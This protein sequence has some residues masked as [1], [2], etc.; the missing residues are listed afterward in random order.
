[1]S[2][3]RLIR[4]QQVKN[5]L[6][7]KISPVGNRIQRWLTDLPESTARHIADTKRN[8]ELEQLLAAATGIPSVEPF[9]I[10][11]TVEDATMTNTEPLDTFMS[12]GA[13]HDPIFISDNESHVA[14]PLSRE[15]LSPED[16]P[17]DPEVE[18]PLGPAEAINI[19][20]APLRSL[21]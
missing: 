7:V 2:G 18:K 21:F 17:K 13:G 14:S 15:P 1:M 19:L 3:D 11:E 9:L 8:K 16:V 12:G 10:T 4:H 6:G 5:L 20:T